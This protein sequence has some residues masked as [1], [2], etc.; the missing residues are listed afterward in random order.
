M[1]GQPP[2][3]CPTCGQ[4]PAAR[5]SESLDP[6][7]VGRQVRQRCLRLGWSPHDLACQADVD[8]WVISV[9]ADG[10]SGPEEA[11]AIAAIDRVL[12]RAES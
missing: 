3:A 9:I 10:Q 8:D 11:A 1:S 4:T 12:K 5:S 7:T 2:R 6:A